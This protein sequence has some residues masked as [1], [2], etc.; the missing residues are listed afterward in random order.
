MRLQR[1]VL[2][3]VLYLLLVAAL[4]WW[5][6]AALDAVAARVMDDTAHL[7]ASEVAGALDEQLVSDLVEGQPGD[8]FRLIGQLQQV[9]KR[10]AMVR[11]LEVV[12]SRGEIFASESFLRAARH[13]SLPAEVFGSR[14][15]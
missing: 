3:L 8:R 12:D 9:T 14:R 5:A 11:S 7:V 2:P 4:A 6:N 1:A 15:D 10:S 13:A